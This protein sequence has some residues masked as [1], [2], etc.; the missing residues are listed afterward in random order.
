MPVQMVRRSGFMLGATVSMGALSFLCLA[1]T[2]RYLNVEEAARFLAIWPLCNTVA[3]ALN[4]P[5]ELS[6]PNLLSRSVPARNIFNL[7][8]ISTLSLGVLSLLILSLVK[9]D[10][11]LLPLGSILIAGFSI[12]F[13][14]RGQCVGH[15]NFARHAL[16]SFSLLAWLLFGVALLIQFRVFTVYSLVVT[17]G[18][19]CVVLGVWG[20][21][22]RGSPATTH[23]NNKHF[24]TIVRA[25]H[26]LIHSHLASLVITNGTLL[27]APFWGIEVQHVLGYA[28]TV[29]LVR[30]P[31]LVLDTPLAP[32]NL[33]IAHLQRAS[34]QTELRSIILIS[35]GLMSASI[36]F[37][38]LTSWFVLPSVLVRFFS[39]EVSFSR[40]FLVLLTL[41]EG[42]K[43]IGSLGRILAGAMSLGRILRRTSSASLLV[44]CAV[45]TVI[46]PSL[47]LLW[48][49]PLFAHSVPCVLL[50]ISISRLRK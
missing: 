22:W 44:F 41:A 29:A 25:W 2:E 9:Q 16:A 37:L 48:I 27:L 18:A 8:V 14:A 28:I 49:V 6:T 35:L 46:T 17:A 43:W 26:P 23:Q 1:V 19:G 40:G 45:S 34:A 10:F 3:L 4:I 47:N 20:L 13:P 12:W 15:G 50:P 7:G 31:Y 38:A 39:L 32:L 21:P 24:K 11:L 42:V 5:L 36:L 30:L 33:R